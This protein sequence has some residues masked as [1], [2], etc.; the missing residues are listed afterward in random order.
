MLDSG[1]FFM[2]TSLFINEDS[3]APRREVPRTYMVK[4]GD[5]CLSKDVRSHNVV[6]RHGV[7]IVKMVPPH[8]VISRLVSP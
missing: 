5:Q 1:I 2:V 3:R 6:Q 4:F 7:L 8:I